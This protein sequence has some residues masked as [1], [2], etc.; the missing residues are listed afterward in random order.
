LASVGLTEKDDQ[1]AFYLA[2]LGGIGTYGR[3]SYKN[4]LLKSY[5]KEPDPVLKDIIGGKFPFTDAELRG[6]QQYL[7]RYK[8][9]P[10]IW[11]V[12]FPFSFVAYEILKKGPRFWH[13]NNRG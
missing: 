11:L 8:R 3:L 13:W 6:A 12:M 4:F 2:V 7:E 10:R 5:I 1:Y 9:S